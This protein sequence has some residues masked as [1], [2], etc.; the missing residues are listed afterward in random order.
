MW[1]F[2]LAFGLLINVHKL[3]LLR[4]GVSSDLVQVVASLT[5]C[6]ATFLPFTYLGL[7][8]EDNMARVEGWRVVKIQICKMS[9]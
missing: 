9:L 6:V 1:C 2:Y 7:P 3:N 5:G 8:V 4:V